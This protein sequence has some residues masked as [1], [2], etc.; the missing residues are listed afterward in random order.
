MNMV[1]FKN[2]ERGEMD[3]AIMPEEYV[4]A[5]FIALTDAILPSTPQLGEML[6]HEHTFSAPEMAIHEYVIYALD[7]Y[8]S[9]QEQFSSSP[10][11]L[12]SPTAVLLNIAAFHI[13]DTDQTTTPPFVTLS[14][15]DRIRTL[16]LL[17]NL[18]LD[19]YLLPPP[20]QNNAGMIKHIT[21]ALNRL[22]CLAITRN[23]LL[24]VKRGYIRQTIEDLSFFR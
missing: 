4:Q 1:V 6:G 19:L 22:R 21:D 14:R 18:S 5:T 3:L 20:F 13:V 23:G 16:S 10:V 24:M 11:P 8:L 2:F 7:N 9:I 12:A 15:R 17:E